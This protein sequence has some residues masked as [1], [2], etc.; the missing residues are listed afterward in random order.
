MPDKFHDLTDRVGRVHDADSGA[1][2][3]SGRLRVSREQIVLDF[4]PEDDDEKPALLRSVPPRDV[5]DQLV[6]ADHHGFVGL[7]GCQLRRS[8]FTPRLPSWIE[9]HAD[10]AVEINRPKG[11]FVS[12]SGV[13]SA[14]AGLATWTQLAPVVTPR[15]THNAEGLV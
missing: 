11:D 6:F 8:S 5:P 12:L 7:D 4:C 2:S 13:R 15:L 3:G 14:V 10:H 1:R 9:V